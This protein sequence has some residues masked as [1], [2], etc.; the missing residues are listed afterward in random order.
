MTDAT[1]AG[2]RRGPIRRFQ[3]EQ[4]VLVGVYM[5]VTER[6][7]LLALATRNARSMSGEGLMAIREH[8]QFHLEQDGAA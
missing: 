5:T 7:A 3:A 4:R 8:L 6:D 2:G 1:K